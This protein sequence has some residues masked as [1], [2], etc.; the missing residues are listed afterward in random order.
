M[1]PPICEQLTRTDI[2]DVENMLSLLAKNG[3]KREANAAFEILRLAY[4]KYDLHVQEPQ[5]MLLRDKM[6]LDKN[7]KE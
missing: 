6:R 1:E 4:I 5:G 2:L 3:Y 7:G